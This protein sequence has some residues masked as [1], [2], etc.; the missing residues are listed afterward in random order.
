MFSSPSFVCCFR[1]FIVVL[2]F[3]P[4]FFLISLPFSIRLLISIFSF[5]TS[6]QGGVI[7]EA[8]TE[9]VKEIE[10]EVATMVDTERGRERRTGLKLGKSIEIMVEEEVESAVEREEE[11]SGIHTL[12]INNF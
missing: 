3:S 6:C 1:S 10:E 5:L 2:S 11:V 9:V 12:F 8:V 7:K 4:L